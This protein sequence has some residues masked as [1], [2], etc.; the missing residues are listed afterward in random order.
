MDSP[1]PIVVHIHLFKNAGT[2][3]DAGLEAH[4]ASEW[5]TFDQP[6]GG[7][8]GQQRLR[9]WL[10]EKPGVSAFSSH[11]LRPPLTS[12]D[13]FEFVPIV[14]LRHPLDRIRSA[15]DFES[16]Q[17]PQTPSAQI[18]SETNFSEWVE[19]HRSKNSSQCRNFHVMS[20]SQ[21]RDDETGIPRPGV[22]ADDHLQ[23]AKEFLS[24]LET[25]GIVEHYD[26][27]WQRLREV[28]QQHFPSFAGA[29]NRKN[30]TPD[31]SASVEARLDDM[32]SQ[33]GIK[34]FRSLRETNELDLELFRWASRRFV[35]A[36]QE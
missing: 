2:S 17:G 29:S 7:T 22:S 3:V 18:A 31:R 30:I 6:E 20:L 4:F 23:S 34:T 28:I 14:F 24:S 27:S 10:T 16:R 36:S 1:R 8:F 11:Q 12:D 25:Y 9:S 13:E 26:E 35:R 5:E 19:F 15:F 33:L 32:R 21:L